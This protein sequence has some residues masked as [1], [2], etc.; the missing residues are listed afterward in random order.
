MI[1]GAYFVFVGRMSFGSFLAFVNSLWRAVTGIF[2]LVH[3][4]PQARR[5]TAV[6]K[7][8]GALRSS[9]RRRTTTR[10]GWCWSKPPVSGTAT[11]RT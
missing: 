7:R 11:A 3:M 4:I 6:L 1:I 9:G 2:D 10:D 8:I 5:N